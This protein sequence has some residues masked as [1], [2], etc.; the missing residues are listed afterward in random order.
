MADSRA[1][2]LDRHRHLKWKWLDP[3]EAGLMVLCGVSI[4][5]FTLTVLCD[6]VTRTIGAPWLWLQQVTT[7]FFAWGVF[8]GMAAATRRLDHFYLT[9]ITKRMTGKPRN[10]I[11]IVNRVVVLLV[12]IAMVIFGWQNALLDLGSFRMPSLIPLTVYTAIVPIAG[13]L[14]ALFTV[15][16]L[17]NGWRH[18]FAGPEDSDD[19]RETLL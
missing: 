11:E 5:M 15:E 9:E 12:A 14:V 1:L 10:A 7:A 4:G 13:V 18:G 8:I 16:Q 2:I 6:V 3:L 19:I 17:V